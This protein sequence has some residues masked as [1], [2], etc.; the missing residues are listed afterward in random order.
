MPK[1][2]MLG[3]TTGRMSGSIIPRVLTQQELKNVREH[4]LNNKLRRLAEGVQYSVKNE[5]DYNH[6]MMEESIV[7]SIV[8]PA[9]VEYKDKTTGEVVPY[10]DMNTKIIEASQA[11]IGADLIS[12]VGIAAL[13]HSGGFDLTEEILEEHLNR[14]KTLIN[15]QVTCDFVRRFLVKEYSFRA[16]R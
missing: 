16:W 14:N 9:T 2:N 7:R 10:S 12:L 15:D 3:C 5:Y 4:S 8:M 13:S 11:K 1:W 6:E